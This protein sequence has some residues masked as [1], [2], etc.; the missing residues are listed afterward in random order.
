MLRQQVIFLALYLANDSDVLLLLEIL[1]I[2]FKLFFEHGTNRSIVN[3]Y[4]GGV[5][6]LNGLS[7]TR[8]QLSIII[9]LI[10]FDITKVKISYNLSFGGCS[11]I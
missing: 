10:H 6:I 2:L 5:K 4:Y 9:S 3:F 11:Q 7:I 8:I 1:C